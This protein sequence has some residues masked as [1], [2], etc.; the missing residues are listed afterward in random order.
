VLHLATAGATVDL[1]TAGAALDLAT[2]G[3]ALTGAAPSCAALAGAVP[4]G[5]VPS[6]AAFACATLKLTLAS[7]APA[8]AAPWHR[9]SGFRWVGW[10]LTVTGVG[11]WLGT[12][13]ARGV[14]VTMVLAG[15]AAGFVKPLYRLI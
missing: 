6:C 15:L 5:V 2:A 14:T 3:A 12:S 11:G 10:F 8:A 9:F 1:T 4:A 7:A 13:P